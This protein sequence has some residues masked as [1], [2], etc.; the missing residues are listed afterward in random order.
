MHR[1]VLLLQA[2]LLSFGTGLRR[3]LPCS[4]VRRS[5]G[6]CAPLSITTTTT[7]TT[8][9]TTTK[10]TSTPLPAAVDDGLARDGLDES[11]PV[12]GTLF[13]I[14]FHGGRCVGVRLPPPTHLSMTAWR[15]E[16]CGIDEAG[17]DCCETDT[18]GDLMVEEFDFADGI[19]NKANAVQFLGGRVALRRLDAL[20]ATRT[21]AHSHVHLPVYIHAGNAQMPTRAL[22]HARTWIQI[23]TPTQIRRAM[24]EVVSAAVAPVLR[25]HRGA[26]LIP[27]FLRGSISHKDQVAVA[28]VCDPTKVVELAASGKGDGPELQTE[29][30]MG[31][32]KPFPAVTL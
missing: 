7:T 23:Q 14:P 16:L 10:M 3:S 21:H 8:T 22:A 26:P 12:F 24:G 20:P 19:P 31:T 13:D 18:M 15:R 32:A 30:G 27:K 1:P 25:N 29:G 11:A 17:N 5:Y 4:P 6:I 28:L 2:M 9:M